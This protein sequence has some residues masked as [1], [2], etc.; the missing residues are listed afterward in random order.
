MHS[1]TPTV[2]LAHHSAI[3]M[4]TSTTQLPTSHVQAPSTVD[5]L[6]QGLHLNS[7]KPDEMQEKTKMLSD[8]TLSG[9][10]ADTRIPDID[11]DTS[12]LSAQSL[13]PEPKSD[14]GIPGHSAQ[15]L[16]PELKSDTRL[17]GHSAT[18]PVVRPG[19]SDTRIP[20]PKSQPIAVAIPIST[21]SL[22]SKPIAAESAAA[23]LNTMLSSTKT[24]AIIS[25]L[26]PHQAINGATS[27]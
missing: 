23:L 16:E 11:T 9:Q 2:D 24:I 22:V 14:T 18:N 4:N 26:D 19:L 12:E 17:P 25:A 10:K 6:I 21:A 20:E 8:T 27:C 13:E 5:T 15:S 1:S 3:P 7:P